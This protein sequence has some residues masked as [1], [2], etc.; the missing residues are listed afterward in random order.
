MEQKLELAKKALTEMSENKIEL[1][2][3]Q[4]K[5]R[6]DHNNNVLPDNIVLVKKEGKPI[7]YSVN[8]GKDGKDR[9]G[10]CTKEKTMN[11]KLELAKKHLMQL[12]GNPQVKS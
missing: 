2:G 10:F 1:I 5:D 3:K 7:G 8:Y 6:L 4:I 12:M 11:E 9:K